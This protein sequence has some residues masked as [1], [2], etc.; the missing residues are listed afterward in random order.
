MKVPKFL[1]WRWP[2]RVAML[3]VVVLGGIMVAGCHERPGITYHRQA[4]VY[5]DRRPAV[6]VHDRE[7]GRHR[8]FDRDRDGRLERGD[9]QDHRGSGDRHR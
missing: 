7:D 1:S 6:T 9:R 4:Y 3:V 2:R 8:T 5:D